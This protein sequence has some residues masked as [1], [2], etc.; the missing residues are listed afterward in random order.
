MAKATI[1]ILLMVMFLG[2]E[3]KAVPVEN[4]PAEMPEQLPEQGYI[5]TH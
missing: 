2:C 4:T 3:E 1:V 5:D